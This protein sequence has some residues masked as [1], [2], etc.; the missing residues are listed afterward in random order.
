MVSF[1]SK[2]H[3]HIWLLRTFGRHWNCSMWR[4]RYI[5]FVR[6]RY[7]C[8]FSL[9]N[10]QVPEG[11]ICHYKCEY[12]D[13]KRYIYFIEYL[14]FFSFFKSSDAA[15]FH[16]RDF[17]FSSNFTITEN[18]DH[19]NVFFT[20]ESPA[21]EDMTEKN[22]PDTFFNATITTRPNSTITQ[23]YDKFEVIEPGVTKPEEV[24]TIDDV[25]KQLRF[26]FIRLFRYSE[27]WKKKQKLLCKWYRI[28]LQ[29]L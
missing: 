21:N 26:S 7:L 18:P 9:L 2:I 14:N 4:I 15:V 6:F 28:V 23:Y 1:A 22:F 17:I 5:T 25:R 29:I 11:M 3:S 20:A 19:M 16:A 27:S 10:V 12:S 13:N 8:S 24:W